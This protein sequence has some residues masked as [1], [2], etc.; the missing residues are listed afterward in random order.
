M[1]DTQDAVTLPAGTRERLWMLA[2]QVGLEITAL[3][4]SEQRDEALNVFA[5]M[6]EREYEA[7]ILN[8]RFAQQ[9]L[10]LVNGG[11]S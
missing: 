8:K 2:A 10:A 7:G 3:N 5:G 6:L 9:A 1:P 11:A 4:T